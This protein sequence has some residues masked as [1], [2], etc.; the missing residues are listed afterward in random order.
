VVRAAAVLAVLAALGVY[1]GVSE[2]L[3]GLPQWGD[4]AFLGLGLMP[5]TLSL[6]WLALPL[7][8]TNPRE[9]AVAAVSLVLLAVILEWAG[10]AVPDVERLLAGGAVSPSAA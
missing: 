3:P 4:V 10:F 8:E 2:D 5:L 1:Y 6:V 7:R 9:L